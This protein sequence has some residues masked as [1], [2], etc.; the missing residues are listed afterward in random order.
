[1]TF[2]TQM[3]IIRLCDVVEVEVRDR[4]SCTLVVHHNLG[5]S[6]KDNI[7]ITKKEALKVLVARMRRDHKE[8]RRKLKCAKKLLVKEKHTK[9]TKAKAFLID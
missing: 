6:E 2:P 3:W 8:A 7:W 9:R 4:N 1:M 5:V